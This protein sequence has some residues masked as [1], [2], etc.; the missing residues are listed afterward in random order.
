MK[1]DAHF[2][3]KKFK[4]FLFLPLTAIAI[5]Y[6]IGATEASY[7]LNIPMI[8]SPAQTGMSMQMGHTAGTP[9]SFSKIKRQHSNKLNL[10]SSIT[11]VECQNLPA[12]YYPATFYYGSIVKTITSKGKFYIKYY[13]PDIPHPPQNSFI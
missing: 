3:N 5:F 6:L 1:A 12:A 8:M 11:C 9:V 7:I 13:S 10:L 2:L 4:F